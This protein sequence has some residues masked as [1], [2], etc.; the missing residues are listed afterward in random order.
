MSKI[1][2]TAELDDVHGFED[3]EEVAVI[4]KGVQ[5]IL[6]C[7]VDGTDYILTNLNN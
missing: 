4:I 5:Y 2:I 7:K 6:E 3:G 1:I